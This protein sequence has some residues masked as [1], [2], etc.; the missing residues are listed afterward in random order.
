MDWTLDDLRELL[1]IDWHAFI[2]EGIRNVPDSYY[3][4]LEVD[5][6]ANAGH[7]W[8][9]E[10]EKEALAQYTERDWCYELYHQLRL[11][12]ASMAEQNDIIKKVRLSG[13]PSKQATYEAV[14]KRQIWQENS[15]VHENT[16]DDLVETEWT[17]KKNCRIPDI[18]LHDP[19]GEGYQIF[20]IEVKRAR[21]SGKLSNERLAD[22]LTA[23]AEYT[24]GLC[25]VYGFFIGLGLDKAALDEAL[26]GLAGR[27]LDKVNCASDRIGIY[28]VND[29][30]NPRGGRCIQRYDLDSSGTNLC[31]R[32]S[33]H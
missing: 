30:E 9:K 22:D 23:L 3:K 28:L 4:P 29:G 14:R 10:N 7:A 24:T 1:S 20:A 26:G 21:Q 6:I 18:L 11:L 19:A 16:G 15:P 31:L 27:Q 8:L 5:F 32:N 17:G 2:E 25:Y 13:E 12:L 33:N